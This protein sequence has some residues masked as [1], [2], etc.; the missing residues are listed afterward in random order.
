MASRA[1]PG[2]HGDAEC[3]GQEGPP[4]GGHQGPPAGQQLVSHLAARLRQAVMVRA[5]HVQRPARRRRPHQVRDHAEAPVVQQEHLRRRD[6][7]H[8][9]SCHVITPSHAI[10]GWDGSLAPI[11]LSQFRQVRQAPL[12]TRIP[13]PAG[14]LHS[15]TFYHCMIR[16]G[17]Q[18]SSQTIRFERQARTEAPCASYLAF[19]PA[20]T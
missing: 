2:A 1:G 12:L 13:L 17:G 20:I 16:C 11:E 6:T 19:C 5:E 9:H 3:G 15:C 18:T 4:S 7:P 8:Q 10:R 14:Q